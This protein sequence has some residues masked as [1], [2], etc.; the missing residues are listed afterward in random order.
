M[1]ASLYHDLSDGVWQWW[2]EGI[3][4]LRLTFER[5]RCGSGINGGVER[6]G[7]ASW[8]VEH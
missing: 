2:R 6:S 5:R 1:G 7:D 3:K 8:D 4:P